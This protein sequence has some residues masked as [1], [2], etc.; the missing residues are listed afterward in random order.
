MK[1]NFLLIII[2]ILGA[3][4]KSDHNTKD[5]DSE[6]IT[7]L[8][9]FKT[10]EA[11]ELKYKIATKG[12]LEYYKNQTLVRIP[13]VVYLHTS[14][15]KGN[16]N[17]L[18]LKDPAVKSILSYLDSKYSAFIMFIPQCPPDM[19][20]EENSMIDI[21]YYLVYEYKHVY[22]ATSAIIIGGDMG[23][24][25]ALKT[26]SV[27]PTLFRAVFACASD[28][29]GIVTEGL[30]SHNI[31]VYMVTGNN[32]NTIQIPTVQDFIDNLRF[33]MGKI[34]D[35]LIKFDIVE[36]WNHLQTC[37]DSY[38]NERLSWICNQIVGYW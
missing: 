38:T 4:S 15:Y 9:G 6:S 20:W 32:D 25:G 28:P 21:L 7:V 2:L 18:Q 19:N 26:A 30:I 1:K 36:G 27:K 12:A 16:D 37:K 33:N 31:A 23:G 14:S 13:L 11:S 35:E 29:T 5:V 10:H 17:E 8:S 34:S 3:C 22:N 24:R